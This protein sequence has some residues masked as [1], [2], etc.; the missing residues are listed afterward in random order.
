MIEKDIIIMVVA[1]PFNYVFNS[2]LTPY[3]NTLFW[4][5]RYSVL[6]IFVCTRTPETF[7]VYTYTYTLRISILVLLKL[8]W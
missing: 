6:E 5:I 1:F 2:F 3:N 4:N 7:R 8:D